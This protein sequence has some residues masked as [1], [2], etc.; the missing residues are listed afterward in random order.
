M[1]FTH[2][3]Q[4]FP[5]ELVEHANDFFAWLG[6]KNQFPKLIMK[7]FIY[8]GT[9]WECQWFFLLDLVER[10]NFPSWLCNVLFFLE[11]FEHV[12]DSFCLTWWKEQA[13]Q[14]DCATFYLRGELCM[15]HVTN[16]TIGV[17]GLINKEAW[18]L[19]VDFVR[20]QCSTTTTCL[21]VKVES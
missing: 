1:L 17:V 8:P 10:T 11:F 18:V 15:I 3:L 7:H 6:G 19:V 9:C 13:S 20:K 21:I 5:L 2:T 16:P 4:L 12:N 14:I